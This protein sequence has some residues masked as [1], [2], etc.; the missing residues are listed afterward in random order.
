MVAKVESHGVVPR[1]GKLAAAISAVVSGTAPVH[2]ADGP[3][4]EELIV[5]ANKLGAVSIQDIAGSLQAMGT[6]DLK[7]GQLFSME[8]YSRFMPSVTY[9]GNQSGAGSIFFRGVADA[10]DAF[11]AGSSAAL[12][13]DEQPLTQ[14]AQVDV[15]MV[16]IERIEALAG[17]QGT[18]FGSSSQSGTLRI[19]TN[20]PDPTKFDAFADVTMN[21]VNGGDTGYDVAGM[22][23]IPL[24]DGKLALRIVGFTAKEAGF[25]DNVRGQTPGSEA[26]AVA[27]GIGRT[28]INGVQYNDG[29][30][31]N[32]A[33]GVNEDNPGVPNL[34]EDDWNETTHTGLRV[35]AKWFMTDKWSMTAA[36]AY[37][38]TDA[39]AEGTYD[40]TVGDLEIIAFGPDSRTDEWTQLA[41][42]IEGDLGFAQF[43]SA[44]AYF[45]RDTKYTQDTTSYTAYFGSFCYDATA[46]YNIYCF[47]PAGVNY[48][49]SD[50][51]GFLTNDQENT[52]FTQEFRLSHQGERI[53]WVAGV[54]WERRTEDWDFDSFTIQEGGYRAQAGFDN[55]VNYWDVPTEATD[56]W[57]FSGD[58]TEWTDTA[59]YGELTFKF[60]EKFSGTVGSRWFDTDMDKTYFVE[61]PKGRLTPAFSDTHG[62][63]VTD[64]PCNDEDSTNPADVGITSPQ[65][66]DSDVAWKFAAKYNITDDK[67]VYALYSEGFRPGGINR[68]RGMPFFPAAFTADFLKNY[69]VGVKTS[70]ADGSVIANATIFLMDWEDYQLEVV[71]PSSNPCGSANALPAPLCGQPWQKVITNVGEASIDGFELQLQWS[72][73]EGLDLG[74]SGTWLDTEIKSDVPEA[75]IAAGSE[76]PFA[77]GYSGA[78]FAQFTWPVSFLGANEMFARIQW[79][80]TGDRLNQVQQTDAPT[81][82]GV[83]NAPQLTMESYSMGDI[84]VGTI[85]KD[86]EFDIFVSNFTDERGQVYHDGTDFEPFWGRSRLSVTR[87]RTFGARFIYSWGD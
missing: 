78:Y 29:T 84:K 49:Y 87:P 19:I 71:D 9:F 7:R 28:S 33:T 3:R 20:K 73:L 8:D 23:N 6:E 22:V 40:P 12:Y 60:T 10:P 31:D 55:W 61:L 37:Q 85:H 35:S 83:I 77:P 32:P 59:V 79:S 38:D 81:A 86:W 5:T 70:W 11:I 43:T 72:P 2:A 41:L 57:W 76:L 27:A 53:D 62:C 17:P 51:I 14:R 1:Y 18:L 80:Y 44:T 21:S 13:L 25:I 30:R 46:S 47:Q 45:T 34:V 50:P 58:R 74:A 36:V 65:G 64:A 16:D 15:R 82:A 52:S 67:M 26:P 66:S 39:D 63:I 56:A 68:N 75:D 42:T 54:F 48:T 69:E 4:I 24:I